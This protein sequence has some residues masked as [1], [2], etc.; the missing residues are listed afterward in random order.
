METKEKIIE[1]LKEVYDPEISIDVYNLGLIYEIN[2]KEQHVD[3]LMTLTSAFC[4]AA[5]M[6]IADVHEAVTKL[7]EIETCDVEVTFEPPFTPEM[8]SDEAKMIAGFF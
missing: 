6:I 2:I 3:I 1:N 4:P 7:E 8:M 5:D